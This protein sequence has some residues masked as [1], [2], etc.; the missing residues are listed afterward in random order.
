MTN[1]SGV[2]LIHLTYMKVRYVIFKSSARAVV[3]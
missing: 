2:L 1:L 3:F